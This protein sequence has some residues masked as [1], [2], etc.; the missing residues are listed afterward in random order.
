[1]PVGRLLVDS[2]VCRNEMNDRT[3]RPTERPFPC[4][5]TPLHPVHVGYD[6][7]PGNLRSSCLKNQPKTHSL[8]GRAEPIHPLRRKKK[9]SELAMASIKAKTMT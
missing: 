2:A 6:S 1:M 7:I 5:P 3:R 9:I 4:H 8:G